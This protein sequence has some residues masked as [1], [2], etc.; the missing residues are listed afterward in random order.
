MNSRGPDL[1]QAQSFRAK[2]VRILSVNDELHRKKKKN[3]KKKKKKK[4]KKKTKLAIYA[5]AGSG[6][7]EG[8]SQL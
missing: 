5:L 1:V 8:F 6:S 7:I 3:Q 2:T 4:K